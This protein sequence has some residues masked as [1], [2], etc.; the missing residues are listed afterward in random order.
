MIREQERLPQPQSSIWDE[1]PKLKEIHPEQFPNHVWI[2]PDGNGRYAET[3]GIPILF[4]HQQGFQT[5]ERV[6]S[7]MRELPIKH[8]T[9]WGLSSDNIKNR[10]PEELKGIMT[11][12]NFGI[13]SNL[14]DLLERNVKFQCIGR[15]DRI[16]PE[17][18]RTIENAE[19]L[20]ESNNGQVL[21][22]AIDYNGKT[23]RL[24]IDQEL[25]KLKYPETLSAPDLEELEDNLL[26]QYRKG[27]PPV[28]LVIRTVEAKEAS[29][30]RTSG[31]GDIVAQ[32]VEVNIPKLLPNTDTEDYVDAIVKYT[33]IKRRFGG[34]PEQ[35]TQ[36]ELEILALAAFRERF[37]PHLKAYLQ[38]RRKEVESITSNP[39]IHDYT[40]HAIE[41][42]Q[43]HGKR[44]RPYVTYL[45]YTTLGGQNTEQALK[46][47]IS[48]ELLH[49][50]GLIH[51]DIIDKGRVRHNMQTTHLYVVDKMVARNPDLDAAHVG[52][53][54][55]IIIGDLIYNWSHEVINSAGFDGTMLKRIMNNFSA[56]EKEVAL[57]EMIDVDM[58]SLDNVT[59]SQIEEK[60]RL[61]TASYTFIW[62]MLIGATLANQDS[63][64]VKV[65][66]KEFGTRLG[67]IFQT[68]DDLMDVMEKE[69]LLGKTTFSDISTRKHTYLTQYVFEN[70]TE[71]QKSMLLSLL[72][73]NPTQDTKTAI[74]KI[75]QDSGAIQ[76]AQNLIE[77]NARRAREAIARLQIADERKSS[78]Y[79]LLENISARSN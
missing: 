1:F 71:E 30:F 23:E 5:I 47:L 2:T 66:C 69:N 11:I 3:L 6:L 28:D 48:L 22:V 61:K 53:S 49:A 64:N 7:R 17:L 73:K 25:I 72:G 79:K 41:I 32:A 26:G 24:A 58:T 10:D 56:M 78:F 74:Q 4:G 15:R 12:I 62:P 52:N 20:T 70:G 46:T 65:F 77:E 60:V 55:A 38:G 9:L 35:T 63:E 14:A 40:N 67:I 37:D 8:V 51:D 27:L 42:I 34:R 54:Q 36:D 50:F 68:Q 75:F 59:F 13:A 45:M 16:S 43:G 19:R 31:I 76:F 33:E 44:I 57:G 29:A 39:N 21:T 18:V